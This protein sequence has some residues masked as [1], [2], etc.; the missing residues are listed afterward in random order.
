MKKNFTKLIALAIILLLSSWSVNAQ[1]DWNFSNTTSFPTGSGYPAGVTTVVSG[2]SITPGVGIADFGV[3]GASGKTIGGIAYTNRFKMN[4]AGY[5][6]SADGDNVPATNMPTVRYLSF[7]VTGNTTI[8][9]DGASNTTASR[10]LFVTDGTNFIGKMTFAGSGG[11]EQ[12]LSYYGPATTLYV[13]SSGTSSSSINLY[14]LRIAAAPPAITSFIVAGVTATIDQTAKTIK[15]ELPYGSSLISLTPTVLPAGYSPTGAQNFTNPVQYSVTDGTSTTNYTVTLTVS[16][17]PSTD[18]TLSDLKVDGT[19]ITGFSPSITNYNQVLPYAYPGTPVV[20]ATTTHAAATKFVTQASGIPG[21]ATIQITAQDGATQG[22][23]IVNFSRT[24]ASTACK[25]LS[26][27]ANYRAAVIDTVANKA[28]LYVQYGTDVSNLT[29]TLSVSSLATYSPS[30]SQNF[31]SPVNYIITAQ[32]GT[33]QRTYAVSVV[34]TDLTFGGPYPYETIFPTGYTIPLFMNSSTGGLSF[35]GNYGSGTTGADKVNWYDNQAETDAGTASVLRLSTAAS[36]DFSLSKCSHI[37][38]GVSATGRRIFQLTIG[39][40]VVAT[41]VTQIG[42]N[43]KATLSYDVNS[44]VPVTINV[45]TVEQ[46][47]GF[48]IGYLNITAL[49]TPDIATFTVNNVQGIIDRTA[50]TINVALPT[51]TDLTAL[52]PTVVLSDAGFTVSPLSG[53]ATNF[54]NSSTTPVNYTVTDGSTP[55]VYAVKITNVSTGIAP[56]KIDGVTFDGKIIHNTNNQSLQVFDP[57]GRLMIS[58]DKDINMIGNA[59]G[60]YIVK[61]MTGTFKIVLTK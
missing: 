45:N 50:A 59:K 43:I 7:P 32:D 36:V 24:P 44:T 8:T 49:P 47:G 14:D 27:V 42:S 29:P 5:S 15:A 21:S 30:G 54:S 20:T 60:V 18:A 11:T 57:T 13:F 23:Y 22:V 2:L 4:G 33:T 1:Q 52:A 6:P 10:N 25:M 48:T 16:I 3:V 61:G 46:T 35:S 40:N 38:V 58:S 53:V 37:D 26:F 34:K 28:V 39:G 56:I 9:V 12:T 51:G 55:K 31:N 17:T 19:T 41:T